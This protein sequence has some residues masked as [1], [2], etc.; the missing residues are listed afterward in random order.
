MKRIRHIGGQKV[1]GG[2]YWN[3]ATGERISLHGEAV[4]PGSSEERY[5]KVRPGWFFLAGPFLGLI[6]AVI[7]PFIGIAMLL[8]LIGKKVIAGLH[9]L[10][11]SAAAF[12]WSPVRAYLTG[13]KGK[14]KKGKKGKKQSE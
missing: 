1:S 12:T 10:I 8:Q 6:Y 7:L 3:F 9:E 14:K 11:G 2:N 4:L 5:Y 13:R